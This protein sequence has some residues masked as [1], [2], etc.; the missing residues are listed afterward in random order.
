[1]MVK[2][3]SLI[4]IVLLTITSCSNT[5]TTQEPT[6]SLHKIPSIVEALKAIGNAGKKKVDKEEKK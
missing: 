3:I 4:M 5:K 2:K 1:M 6:G